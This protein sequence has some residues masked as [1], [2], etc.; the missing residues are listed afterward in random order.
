MGRAGGQDPSQAPIPGVKA[1]TDNYCE[2]CGRPLSGV[3]HEFLRRLRVQADI[4]RAEAT[5]A[6]NRRKWFLIVG[7][8]GLSYM[9]IDV[10]RHLIEAL[11]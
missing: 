6:A 2:D 4:R 11:A 8:F 10:V 3:D 7:G 1:M 5:K 9:V